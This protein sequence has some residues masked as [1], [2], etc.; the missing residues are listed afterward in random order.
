MLEFC[1]TSPC[2]H[3]N[4]GKITDANHLSVVGFGA[5]PEFPTFQR[6]ETI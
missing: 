4:T 6:R 3:A 2:D 1:K 5:Q